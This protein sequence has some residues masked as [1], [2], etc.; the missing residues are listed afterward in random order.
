MSGKKASS[1]AASSGFLGCVRLQSQDIERLKN[2]GYQK[3]DLVA[4][5]SNPLL[6]KGQVVVSLQS[7]D[8]KGTGSMNAVVDN[9]GN[10]SFGGGVNVGSTATEDLP[11]G[12]EERRSANGRPY[13][14]NHRTK[15]TQWQRPSVR[16]G[17]GETPRNGASSQNIIGTLHFYKLK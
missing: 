1:A 4:D 11:E 8:V 7:R 2:T 5:R 15:S 9:M 17:N 3:I 10:L 14:V 13:Y 6:V 12:W 16:L